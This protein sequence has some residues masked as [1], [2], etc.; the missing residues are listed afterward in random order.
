MIT[1]Y[2][3][4]QFIDCERSVRARD[5]IEKNTRGR[6][7]P[8]S[9]P[10][11]RSTGENSLT[12]FPVQ[13]CVVIVVVVVVVVITQLSRP[14]RGRTMRASSLTLSL[15]LPIHHNIRASVSHR[16]SA[17]NGRATI[18]IIITI[19][20]ATTRTRTPK[21]IFIHLYV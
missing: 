18:I 15:S 7:S 5:F 11:P 4:A 1:Y 3:D 14:S 19:I 20:I 8:H 13:K 16:P 12:V 10:L 2:L 17:Y 21:Y 6:R 9:R